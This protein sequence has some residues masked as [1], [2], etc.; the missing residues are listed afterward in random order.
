MIDSKA[1]HKLLERVS[2]A[3]DFLLEWVSSCF[4]PVLFFSFPFLSFFTLSSPFPCFVLWHAAMSRQAKFCPTPRGSLISPPCRA[5]QLV[6][7]TPCRVL[8]CRPPAVADTH[9]PTCNDWI[10]LFHY[11]LLPPVQ[12]SPLIIHLNFPDLFL[13]TPSYNSQWFRVPP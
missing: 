3:S 6:W 9:P 5:L 12:V 11:C 7:Q 1:A 2:S 8:A 4:I 13:S 10:L